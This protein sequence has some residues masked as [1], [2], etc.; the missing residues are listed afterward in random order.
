MAHTIIIISF[1]L[2]RK[3]FYRTKIK[4]RRS[5]SHIQ[6]YPNSTAS[7][8]LLL[9]AGDI[10]LNP[11]P[12]SESNTSHKKHRIKRTSLTISNTFSL[13][14]DLSSGLKIVHWNLHSIAP[15]Q[16]N[17]KLD[18]LKLLLSNPGKE[19]HILGVTVTWLDGNFKD[20]EIRIPGYNVERLDCDKV[21]LPF[22]KNGGGGIAVYIHK[23]I[24]Y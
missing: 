23:S 2:S 3:A 12:D 13:C 22:P 17:T 5:N 18:E 7:F 21:S 1:L 8:Q 24:P 19:C 9:C 14:R 20:S 4:L 16:G 15:H 10:E 6:Y 11:G